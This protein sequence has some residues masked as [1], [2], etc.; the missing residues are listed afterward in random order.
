MDTHDTVARAIRMEV[1][2]ITG[3]LYLVFKVID[4]SFKQ[5]VRDNWMD[6][7]ELVLL[8]KT[9]KEVRRSITYRTSL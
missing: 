1:D 8:G 4:E 7:V 9:L 2:P 3:D 6:D 5:R